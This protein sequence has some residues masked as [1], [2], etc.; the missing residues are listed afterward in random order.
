MCYGDGG[1]MALGKM[2]AVNTAETTTETRRGRP[3]RLQLDQV[4]EAALAIGLQQLT[5]TS[6]AERL[7]VAKTVLYGYVSSR[8]E[9]VRHAATYASRRYR[10]P[11]D[12]GQ[13]WMQWILEY[14]HALFEVLTMEGELLERWLSGEQSASLEVDAAEMWLRALTARGFSGEETLRLRRAVSHLVIG[15]AAAHKRDMAWRA[16]GH[17]RPVSARKAVMDRPVQEVAM[18]REH[19]DL[20]AAEVTDESWE[21]ELYLM[22]HGVNAARSVLMSESESARAMFR[23]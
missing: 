22:L 5:M 13:P 23:E 6:V 10:F 18:L 1:H 21:Y 17:P 9:L 3:R 20:F 7:G 8:E 14:A 4:L 15:A 12:T 11:Q 19:L 2:M 16:D